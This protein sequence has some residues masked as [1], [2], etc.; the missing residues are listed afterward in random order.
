MKITIKYK[1]DHSNNYLEILIAYPTLQV[2]L[3]VGSVKIFNKLV[4]NI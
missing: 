3:F 1:F 2:T 4:H